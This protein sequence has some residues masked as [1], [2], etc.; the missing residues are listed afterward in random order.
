MVVRC[1]GS[2]IFEPVGSQMVVKLSA[3]CAG[4]PL[5]PGR[6]LILLSRKCGSLDVS[7]PCGRPQHFTG[8]ALH[9]YFTYLIK[10]LIMSSCNAIS[11]VLKQT[12]SMKFLSLNDCFLSL[13]MY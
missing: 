8:T 12:C 5:T 3:L 11:V 1:R 7:Q 13:K 10:F 2:H 9:S 6:F 4:C